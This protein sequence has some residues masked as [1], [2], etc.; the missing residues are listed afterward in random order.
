MHFHTTVQLFSDTPLDER[1]CWAM[2][3]AIAD[4]ERDTPAQDGTITADLGKR[5]IDVDHYVEATTALF[6]GQIALSVAMIA[7]STLPLTW[8]NRLT[9]HVQA[10]ED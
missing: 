4:A 5:Q 6:A 2:Q 3:D 8:D 9:M 10:A 7:A 1:H